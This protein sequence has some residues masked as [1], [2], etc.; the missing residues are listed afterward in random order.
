MPVS[1]ALQWHPEPFYFPSK[2]YGVCINISHK[3]NK[4]QFSLIS[5][6]KISLAN[7]V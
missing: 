4:P 7:D 2:L 3:F 6:F 5:C 1:R